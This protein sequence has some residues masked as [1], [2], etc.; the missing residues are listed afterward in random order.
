MA[1]HTEH[2]IKLPDGIELYYTDSGPP[3]S[4]SYTT[5]VVLH[6]S[7]FTGDGLVPLHKYAHQND[8]RMILWNRR[9]YRGSTKYTDAELEDLKAGRKVFQDRLA[10]QLAWFFEHFIKQENTAKLSV[11]RKSGGFILAGWS[12]G[13]ATALSLLS[14][15]DA[16]PKALYEIVE[17]YLMSVVLYDPPFTALGYT[18]PDHETFYQPMA[19]PDYHTLE[20]KY[21]NFQHWVSS[22][23]KH[24]DIASGKPSGL[25]FAKRT[26]KQTVS[27]WT[28][29]QKEKYFDKVAAIRTELPKCE[30]LILLLLCRLA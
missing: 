8:L 27:S 26:D 11:D 19:D 22:Y 25:S 17:P 15:P 2:T 30:P 29:E 12:F 9:D 24:P 18:P 20:Q 14:D 1:D 5:L 21:D 13:N 4:S 28:E 6:G 7:A 16:I 23:Y 3:S 10:V